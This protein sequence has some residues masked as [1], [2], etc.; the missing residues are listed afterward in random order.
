LQIIDKA[1]P[2]RLLLSLLILIIIFGFLPFLLTIALRHIH[3]IISERASLFN[4][5]AHM[6]A[7]LAML[8][9]ALGLLLGV[10]VGVFGLNSKSILR[11]LARI[12]VWVICG[13]PLLVQVL[14]FYYALPAIIPALEMNELTAGICALAL[15][16]GAYNATVVKSGLDAIPVTQMEAGISLGL[17]R[18]QTLRWIIFPQAFQISLAPLMNNWIA[19]LKDTSLVSVIGVVE[20]TLAATRTNSETFLPIPSL[21]TIALIYLGMSSV[22]QVCVIILQPKS[23]R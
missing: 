4:A 16:V 13:T 15:N 23:R 12:Y 11:V 22:M 18:F 1:L 5:A 7:K 17:S 19:L 20:L 14:F 3:P 10:V 21:V 9:G 8:S 2:K 6:T